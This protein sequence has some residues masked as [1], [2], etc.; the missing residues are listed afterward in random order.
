MLVGV[1]GRTGSGKTST[2]NA[3]LGYQELLPTNNEEASTAVP[4]KIA[5]N[6]NDDP[7]Y[8]FRCHVTFLKKDG[9]KSQLDQFFEDIGQRNELGAL[10][11][12]S[13]EDEEAFRN[14]NYQLKPALEMIKV[15]FGLGEEQAEQMNARRILDTRPD[16]LALLGTTKKFNHKTLK[17]I[18]EKIKPYIDS[19][20]ADHG[21]SGMSFAAW[22]LI[23]QVDLFVK[24]DI[25]KNGVVLVDLPGAADA[26]ESRA[27][28]AQRYSGQLAATLVVVEAKRAASDSTNVGLM[29]KQ[30]EMATMLNGNFHKNSFCVC[31]SQIDSIDRTA[32]LRKKDARDNKVLQSWIREEEDIK[33]KRANKVAEQREAEKELRSLHNALSS[34]TKKLNKCK[35]SRKLISS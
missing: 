11:N 9:L 13:T 18:S 10:A 23:A 20:E 12:R 7:A 27:A 14:Y 24:S 8:T 15:V 2:L 35:E 29:S 1:S 19:T 5:Y 31:V 34:K 28:V 16:V 26:V 32:A 17:G 21:K 3:L 6:Y 33:T 25:L 4:C 22:P 30:R